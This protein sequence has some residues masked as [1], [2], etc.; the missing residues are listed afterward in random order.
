MGDDTDRI[1]Q[2]G[3]HVLV[4]EDDYFIA[5]DLAAAVAAGGDCV[6]GPVANAADALALIARRGQRI[7]AALLDI[8][9]GEERSDVV[10][11]ALAARRVAFAFVTGSRAGLAPRHAARPALDKPFSYRG[12]AALLDRLAPMLRA[13]DAPP[14]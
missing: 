10:A 3:R 14:A 2:G 8:Q 13:Q 6:L 12:I 4:V 11:D 7:D 9:L 5:E 1:E